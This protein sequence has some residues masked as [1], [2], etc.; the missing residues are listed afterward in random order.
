M[1]AFPNRQIAVAAVASSV[2]AAGAGALYAQRVPRETVS[3]VAVITRERLDGTG[4]VL[5]DLPG[6]RLDQ[7]IAQLPSDRALKAGQVPDGWSVDQRGRQLRMSGPA[8]DSPSFRLDG[9]ADILRDFTG[10]EINIQYGL[11]GRL[12]PSTRIKIDS[13][14]KVSS[15]ANLEGILTTPPEASPGQ[16]L[17]IGVVPD[18]RRGTWL[19]GSG[20]AT[21][22][23]ISLDDIG[24]IEVIRDGAR[25]IYGDGIGGVIDAVLKY[26]AP[27]PFISVFPTQGTYDRVQFTDRFG[28]MTVSAPLT[29]TIVPSAGCPRAL[30]GG[31]P[32]TF[33]GQAA[34][35]SG[36]FPDI[37]SAYGLLLDGKTELMPWAVSPTTVMLGIPD[38][39]T[40]GA[41]T[42]TLPGGSSSVT[43]GVI[44]MQGSID[45]NRLW[46]GESTTMRLRV[47]G[48]E[49]R[50]PITILNRTPGII[51]MEGGEYQSISTPGGAD[52]AITRNVR[53]IQKGNFTIHYSVASKGCTG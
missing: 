15:T 23:M 17:L 20:S 4:S 18:Y 12:E 41:H 40:P 27:Q 31:S 52:N 16:P 48:T 37:G 2:I 26:P 47:V 6:R 53:G 33:T 50:F 3:P 11:G 9:G 46:R 29:F 44:T 35:V 38:G 5:L 21:R 32:L 45:Q 51:D 7:L 25:A 14:P 13:W 49:E 42:V 22:P 30:T 43:I 1:R 19:L 8:A 39:T 24:R 10:R 34:C 28:E 36:C